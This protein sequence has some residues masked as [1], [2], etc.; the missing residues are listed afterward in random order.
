MLEAFIVVLVAVVGA[1]SNGVHATSF[2]SGNMPDA[3]ESHLP[4]LLPSVVFDPAP[5]SESNGSVW[6]RVKLV[7]LVNLTSPDALA[8]KNTTSADDCQAFCA[9]LSLCRVWTYRPAFETTCITSKHITATILN[10]PGVESGSVQPMLVPPP[11]PPIFPPTPVF[12]KPPRPNIVIMFADDLGFGDLNSF[13]HPTSR[14][15]AID[16]LAHTGAKLVQ[17][18]SAAAICSPSRGSL[19]TGRLFP[20]LGIYPGV[21]SP[22]SKSGLQLNETTLAKALGSVGYAT[23]GLGKW[24]LGVQEYLPTNHGFD[25]YFGAPMTQNECYSNIRN[26]GS[27]SPGGQFGPCPILNGS[28]GE[29]KQQGN[30]TYP[31][32]PDAV[33]ML[34]IDNRY[35]QAMADFITSAV[36][37]EKPF[38]FYFSSHHTHAP[39]FASNALTNSTRRG[40]FGDSLAMLDRS[41]AR[42]NTLLEDLNVVNNTLVIFSADNG[43][44]LIWGDLGGV[45][46]DLRCGKGTTWEGGHRV[47]TIAKWP[48]HIAPNTV[49]EDVTSSLDWFPT[50]STL[51]GYTMPPGVAIDGVDISSVL[52]DGQSTRDRFFYYQTGGTADLEAARVGPYKIRLIT[53]GSHCA[54][55]Y[56]DPACYAPVKVLTNPTLY[57]LERDPGEKLDIAAHTAE[58]DLYAPGLLQ[59]V[60]MQKNAFVKGPPYISQG[61]S[62]DRFPCCIKCTPMPDCCRCPKN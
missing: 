27:T 39:Q 23:G 60:A 10:F 24:H 2:V 31:E 13:G 4:E 57:N 37:K 58:Y 61:T 1:S 45:N 35:D 28:T 46:G 25:Y 36:A 40:L 5:V 6:Y 3:Q 50:F 7:S 43:G 34:D 53:R 41:V 47:P 38:F 62:P 56:P 22:L 48:G 20:R 21:F 55:T 54:N 52:V 11:R 42:L 15:P 17:Y 59:L 30:G 44:S 49:I 16:S 18:Y 32:D 19:M 51:A 26:P 14:T 8:Q 33:D 29:V 12:K 9:S